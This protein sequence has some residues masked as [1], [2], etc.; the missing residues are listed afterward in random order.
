MKKAFY[1]LAV[2]G[3]GIGPGTYAK[4]FRCPIPGDFNRTDRNQYEAIADGIKYTSTYK[5]KG[6]ATHVEACKGS[7]YDYMICK[8]ENTNA[9]PSNQKMFEGWTSC[10]LKGVS[11]TESQ[12]GCNVSQ[13]SKPG[14]CEM[15]CMRIEK[16]KIPVK[17]KITNYMHAHEVGIQLQTH[18]STMLSL[19]IAENR[20]GFATFNVDLEKVKNNSIFITLVD[21]QR[22][23]RCQKSGKPN[24]DEIAVMT[25]LGNV[26]QTVVLKYEDGNCTILGTGQGAPPR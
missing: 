24:D 1:I 12:S 25:R 4:I 22:M 26:L 6:K 23:I 16:G 5:P 21:G 18:P 3:M 8:Y 17:V 13:C 20:D 9:L 10:K 7:K 19:E 2:L 11:S 15:D 14:L